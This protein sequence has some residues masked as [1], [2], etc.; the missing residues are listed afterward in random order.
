M[1]G[2]KWMASLYPW[3][4]CRRSPQPV[5]SASLSPFDAALVNARISA[6][7]DA[8]RSYIPGTHLPHNV[9]GD[10]CLLYAARGSL[11][12]HVGILDDACG[13]GNTPIRY[14]CCTVG[15]NG[16]FIYH[17]CLHCLSAATFTFGKPI[18]GPRDRYVDVSQIRLL[19]ILVYRYVI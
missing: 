7:P 6:N 3:T 4:T 13:L 15:Q 12:L 14:V 18:G 11:S 1:A 17:Y 9:A 16:S 10:R 2:T 8:Q 19:K 5:R